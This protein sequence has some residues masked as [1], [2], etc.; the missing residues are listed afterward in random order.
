MAV[1]VHDSLEELEDSDMET[2]V[3]TAKEL[4]ERLLLFS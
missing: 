2:F 4:L 3:T 1:E